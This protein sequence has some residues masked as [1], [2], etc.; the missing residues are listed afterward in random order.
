MFYKR[1]KYFSR[2]KKSLFSEIVIP[3]IMLVLACLM[4]KLASNSDSPAVEFTDDL[5][6]TPLNIPMGAVSG[7]NI[8]SLKSL[9]A[10]PSYSV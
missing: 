10:A 7:L 6:T 9:F 2:D 1:F 5:I 4:T 3:V 8:D